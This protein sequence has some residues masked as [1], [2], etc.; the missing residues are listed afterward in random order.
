MF[1]WR[2]ELVEGQVHRAMSRLVDVDAVND[3]HLHPGYCIANFGMRGEGG[4]IL[5]ALR[6]GE[7]LGVVED[8][9]SAA[10][11]RF[12]PTAWE[13]ARGS[14]HRPRKR[15]A[16]SLIHTRDERQ[17]FLPQLALVGQAVPERR[18]Q[19]ISTSQVPMPLR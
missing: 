1:G 8:A 3:L 13:H 12:R 10:K 15:A 5:L 18:A 7:L 4:K 6:L 14:D 16:A 17:A 11:A 9:E 2:L 19:C